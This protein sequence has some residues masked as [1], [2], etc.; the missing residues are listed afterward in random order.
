MN[1]ISLLTSATLDRI[2]ADPLAHRLYFRLTEEASRL[3]KK[4]LVSEVGL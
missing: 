2:I 4:S 3:L 1:P